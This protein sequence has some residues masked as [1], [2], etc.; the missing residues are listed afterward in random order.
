[1]KFLQSM[2][3]QNVATFYLIHARYSGIRSCIFSRH[4]TSDD[5]EKVSL[6][7]KDILTAATCELLQ[8]H[9]QHIEEEA[10]SLRIEIPCHGH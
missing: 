10:G 2:I 4:F 6:N 7:K 9:W 5:L 8:Q 1:M 3:G